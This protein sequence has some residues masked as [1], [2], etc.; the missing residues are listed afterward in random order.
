[1][2]PNEHT[3]RDYVYDTY[4]EHMQCECLEGVGLEVT[5][6]A[7]KEIDINW[8]ERREKQLNFWLLNACLEIN[9][10]QC[11][12]DLK[13]GRLCL[14]QWGKAFTKKELSLYLVNKIKEIATQQLHLSISKE[15]AEYLKEEV[16]AS[17]YEGNSLFTNP[18]RSFW[19]H[20]VYFFRHPQEAVQRA[21]PNYL[22]ALFDLLS[23]V[24]EDNRIDWARLLVQESARNYFQSH[25]NN[26]INRLAFVCNVDCQLQDNLGISYGVSQIY[27]WIFDIFK[28]KVIAHGKLNTP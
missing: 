25:E 19:Q 18:L 17:Y 14:L 24:D 11:I 26:P 8:N 10:S 2:D 5:S 16:L 21:V 9:V 20:V 6:M 28:H 7:T 1:M 22:P 27:E 12:K 4:R 23:F 13:E 3:I 15:M